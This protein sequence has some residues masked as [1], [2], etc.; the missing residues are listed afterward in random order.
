MHQT[1]NIHLLHGA[2]SREKIMRRNLVYVTQNRKEI[3]IA[4]TTIHKFSEGK[5]L[6]TNIQY[7]SIHYSPMNMINIGPRP[8]SYF[9]Q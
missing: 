7:L 1:Q 2:K 8:L 5:N 9:L 4:S 3:D 6:E